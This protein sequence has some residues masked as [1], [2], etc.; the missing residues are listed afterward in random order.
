MSR[1]VG[2]GRVST[3]GQERD[4]N[5][6][7]DQRSK[8]EEAGCDEIVLE[9]YT[10]TK[11]ERPKFTKLLSKLEP[12]D[13]LIVCKVDRFARTLREG[14]EVVEDLMQRG[15]SVHILNLGLLEDTPNG[16]LML[17]MWLAFA[18]FER[19][20]I[21]ERTSAGKAQARE[22]NPEYKEGRKALEI[23]AAFGDIW[24]RVT[25]GEQTV[26]AACKELGI[27]R[28]TWYKWEK[29]SV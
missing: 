19:D 4:G 24:A 13:T 3:K 20:S 8:L 1:R 18:Q 16:R 28:S 26:T 9:A 22:K 2:Y 21:I 14:L 15:I 5:S 25:A 27:S 12:G 11:M 10:G 6:L 23:P 29:V 7:A 17:H